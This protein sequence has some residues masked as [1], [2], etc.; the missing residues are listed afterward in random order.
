MSKMINKH[1][2]L[3]YSPDDG[4][5]YFTDCL[6]NDQTSM[7]YE[8]EAAAMAAYRTNSITWD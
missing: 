5:W 2:E 1:L 4:G 3:T 7:T 6:K 8:T